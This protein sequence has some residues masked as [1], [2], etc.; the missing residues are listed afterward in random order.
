MFENVDG[1]TDD[2]RRT[3]DA[4]VTA[5]LIAHLR[6][7]GSG[8]LKKHIDPYN[9]KKYTIFLQCI[10]FV[11]KPV[12]EILVLIA[13]EGKA[14]SSLHIHTVAVAFPAHIQNVGTLMK[15]QVKSLVTSLTIAVYA[16]L[17]LYVLMDSPCCIDTSF[18][19]IDTWDGSIVLFVCVDDL[20]LVKKRHQYTKS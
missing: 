8:E 16:R 4:G 12:Y 1:R 3:T 2:G 10:N 6:A 14:Q 13:Q 9:E 18:C 5:I 19:C 20:H 15:V 7:F 11:C 17:T